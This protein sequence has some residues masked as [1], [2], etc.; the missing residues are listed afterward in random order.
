MSLSID[1]FETEQAR[2]S[3]LFGGAMR[4]AIGQLRTSIWKLHSQNFTF[5]DWCA[6]GLAPLKS[7][8]R[9]HWPSLSWI[10]LLKQSSVN[11]GIEPEQSPALFLFSEG[12]NAL[13]VNLSTKNSAATGKL[14]LTLVFPSLRASFPDRLSGDFSRGTA[15]FTKRKGLNPIVKLP[16]AFDVS[17][18]YTQSH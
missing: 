15:L 13:P 6:P 2:P 8:Y 14:S 18:C 9:L 4:E 3:P 12:T 1:H 17:S 11:W 5:S 7:G 10:L 16:A